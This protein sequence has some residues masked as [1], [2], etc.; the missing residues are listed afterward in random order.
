LAETADV[1]ALMVAILEPASTVTEAGIWRAALLLESVTTTLLTAAA[2]SRTVQANVTAPV[3]LVGQIS[4]VTVP[5]PPP[6]AAPTVMTPPLAE[7]VMPV[8]ASEAAPTFVN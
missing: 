1:V 4:C 6:W 5:P 8:P 3:T 2:L 7:A